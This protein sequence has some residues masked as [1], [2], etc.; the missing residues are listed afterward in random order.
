MAAPGGLV[1]AI[2]V[3]PPGDKSV[4]HRA[5][6]LAA[7]A[8][9]RSLLE[10]PL[11][12]LDARSMAGALR[13]LG[14]EISP[15][16]E[17]AAVVVRGRGLGGLRAPRHWLRCGNSGTTARFL[18]GVLAGFPFAVRLTGDASLRRRPMRRVT[19]PLSMMGA[20][21]E[22]LAGDGL[23]LI[24]HGGSLRP[25]TYDLPVAAAQVKSAL[26]L[27]G[28][29]GRVPVRLTEPAPSRDHTERMLAALGVPLERNGRSLA[30]SPAER[31]PSFQV[32]VPGDISSAAFMVGAALLR[33]GGEVVLEEVGVNPTR[34]GVLRVLERMGAGITVQPRGE[35]LGE[36]LGDLVI[37]PSALVACEVTAE[38]VPSLIDE[39]PVLA[40]LA[41]RAR[42][43]SVFR[44]VAEL[45]V[46]ESNR[47]ELIARNLRSVGVTA[48]ASADTLWVEGTAR[49]PGG[50]VE[51]AQ[52]HRLA[53][54]F[55]VLGTVPGARVRLSET[56]SVA[57]SY[58]A[59]FNDLKRVTAA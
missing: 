8:E 32:R 39:I 17:G 58:P 21:F 34:A 29:V 5:L 10:R 33:S 20:R 52:D 22:E 35:T 7:L 16:R 31:I 55:A 37:R 40:V 26:L 43:Q 41:S 25:L 53:M 3:R 56:A 14:V 9:G 2:R 54:G 59:F 38:E 36:P 49:P 13:A 47:L 44:G 42:G 12:S 51:T 24:V 50:R 30:L 15:L 6:V 45:R 57:V 11:A 27:A 1:S 19:V 4:T 28:L 46:K 23:P 48:E 18:L